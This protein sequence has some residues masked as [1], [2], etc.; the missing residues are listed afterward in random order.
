[1]RF[2]AINPQPFAVR[3]QV[4]AELLGLSRTKFQ[5]FVNRGWL[6]PTVNTP[7]LVLYDAEHVRKVWERIKRDGWP[8]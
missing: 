7:A 6:T 2:S 3:P 5:E 1:M 8:K 4:A